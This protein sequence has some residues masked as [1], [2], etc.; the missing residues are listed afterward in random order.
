MKKLFLLLVVAFL[1]ANVQAQDVFEEDESKTPE[2]RAKTQTTRLDEKLDL[3]A[4]QEVKI[5]AINLNTVKEMDIIRADAKT[6]KEAGNFNAQVYRQ[7]RREIQKERVNEIRA[8]LDDTQKE[9]FNE[10]LSESRDNR[11]EK[12]KN[13]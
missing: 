4:D 8:E 6:Q 13:R 11:Q 12:R 3:S 7:K 2:E 10:I 5:E 9:K 1:A